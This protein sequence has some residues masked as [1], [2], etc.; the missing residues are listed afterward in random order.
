MESVVLRTGAKLA[1]EGRKLAFGYKPPTRAFKDAIHG[2]IPVFS[3]ALKLYERFDQPE[4]FITHK[5]LRKKARE[6]RVEN[7]Y[8]VYKGDL[9]Q[10]KNPY[11]RELK[12]AFWEGDEERWAKN[13]WQA[14]NYID[15]ELGKDK[16]SN[17]RARRKKA[18]SN[19]KRSL[20]SYRP[21]SFTVELNGRKQSKRNEF[22]DY[23]SPKEAKEA[24]RLETEYGYLWRR[25]WKTVLNDKYKNKY[26]ND[27]SF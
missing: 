10:R 4:D 3:Q 20:K 13:F 14:V 18:F 21:I 22:L 25:F 24:K 8:T 2:T 26:S 11:Y 6:F 23:L 7:G 1:I 19:I 16:V 5:N 12:E 17:K 15:D 9:M 27:V